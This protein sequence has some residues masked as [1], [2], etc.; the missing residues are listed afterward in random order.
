MKPKV[1]MRSASGLLFIYGVGHTI[2]HFTRHKTHDVV[3]QKVMKTMAE[4]KVFMYGQMRSFDEN[5]N[6]MSINMIFS[7]LSF[8]AILWI[9]SIF[10]ER[11]RVMV[12]ASLVAVSFCLLGYTVTGFIYFFPAP[13]YASLFSAVLTLVAF[14]M[15]VKRSPE[16]EKPVG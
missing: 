2:I 3:A 7:L 16:A 15:M 9:L 14:F 11:N 5:Y 1:L 6:G 12:R 13:A 10:A 4:Y 8:S